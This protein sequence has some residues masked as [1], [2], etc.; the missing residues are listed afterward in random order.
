MFGSASAT[1]VMVARSSK[2][3][4]LGS[5]VSRSKT[6]MQVM[7][8]RNTVFSSLISRKSV[9]SRFQTLTLFAKDWRHSFTKSVSK[10]TT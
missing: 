1:R 8:A 5:P 2:V 4:F 3:L 6:L 7:P 9:P 10:R